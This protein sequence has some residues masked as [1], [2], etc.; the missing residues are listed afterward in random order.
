LLAVLV[1][2]TLSPQDCLGDGALR[3]EPPRSPAGIT[4]A[5]DDTRVTIGVDAGHPVITRLEAARTPGNWAGDGLRVPLM[6]RVWVGEREFAT[7]WQPE[8]IARDRQGGTLTLSFTNAEPSLLLRSTWRARPGRGPV[9]H[10]LDFENLSGERVTISHQDSLTLAGLRPGGAAT[11][12]WTRRGG[13]NASTQGGTFSEPVSPTLNLQLSSNCEDG[14]SAVPWMA[15]QVGEERGLYVGWEFSGPGRIEAKGE[16]EE[17]SVSVG[18]NPGFRTDVEPGERLLI[19]PAFVGCYAG[20]L[21]EGGYSLHRFI[22]EKLRPRVP[23]D[24][25]DPVLA[26]NLYL[27][28][29]GTDATEADVLRCAH[30]C[31]DLGFEVF[32]PDAM[33]FPETGDWR[34]DPRRFP[35]GIAPIEE[36]VRRSGMRMAL[37][38]A[39]TNGG[40]SADP[41]ALSVRGPVGHPDWFRGP[42][43]ADWQPGPFYGAQLCLG[44]PEALAWACEKTQWLVDRHHLDYLKHDCG[45]IVTGCSQ[46]THRHHYGVDAG[47]WAT[48]GYYHVQE[49]LRKAYPGIILE[50]C[51]GGGHIKD[52]GIIQRTHYTVT[53]D[54][55]SNLP[56][57]QSIW[58]STHAFPPLLL[59]AYTYDNVYPVPG[60]TPGPFLWRSAMMSAWQIDPTD[61]AMWTDEDR[62]HAKRAVRVYK[63]WI[64][65]ILHD[66]KVYHVL[67]RPDGVSW[68]G[69]FYWSPSLRKGTL[70]VFRPDSP[71][72]RKTVRLRG[73]EPEREYLIWSE[74]GGVSVGRVTGAGLMER[75][76]SIKL[77]ERY[78]SDL[79]Y[80]Q[81]GA[82]R[83]PRLP[84][85]VRSTTP[86]LVVPPGVTFMSDMPW[87]SSTAGAGN[88]VHRDTS[89]YGRAIAIGGRTYPKGVWTHAFEDATPADV[90]LDIAGR[91]LVTFA[92]EVGV[93]DAA[94]GGSVQFQVLADGELR[95]QSP[96]MRPGARHEFHVD[97]AGARQVTLRVLNGGDGYTC[98]HAAWGLAQFLEAGATG[99]G[100]RGPRA[101]RQP[102]RSP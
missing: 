33:W 26:Y 51:S 45:P 32:M 82:L 59:Q 28:A 84:R 24:C 93:D 12:W 58:D 50:N 53:T 56:D 42:V 47:Y 91:G 31:R 35:R 62:A 98:D 69:L 30:V 64:R 11:A 2:L 81:D 61:T 34:W 19:P 29:G 76:V 97:V 37:W 3:H 44:C 16:G 36:Y 40:V 96:V 94:R 8:G 87:V 46:T 57:R 65:P 78:T 66:V 52:F 21:D 101:G 23:R 60:D 70:Y 48:M 86:A 99:I 13:G 92:A 102:E 75:G 67:P 41:G 55:L 85:P 4:L 15:A 89:Y 27:D 71:A 25:P 49:E 38:C 43:G 79:I 77:P 68:D 74:D 17:L 9:E 88:Q 20:D 73:L 100:E 10:W 39:W 95:A 6:E 72:S 18:L 83:E 54:T 5:T 90:V 22:V 63:S 14:A 1:T 80:V 7:N